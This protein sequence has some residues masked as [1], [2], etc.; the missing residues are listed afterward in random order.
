MD[1]DTS[2]RSRMEEVAELAVKG[3]SALEAGDH[4]LLAKLMN[5]NFELRR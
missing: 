5:R 3:R 4:L 2:I 1:G